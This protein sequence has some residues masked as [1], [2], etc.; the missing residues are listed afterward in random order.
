MAAQAGTAARPRAQL[1]TCR[2][3]TP[4][5]GEGRLADIGAGEEGGE[6]RVRER[7]H[8]AFSIELNSIKRAPGAVLTLP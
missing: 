3:V 8:G 2:G 4:E 6:F 7:A 5:A 1:L